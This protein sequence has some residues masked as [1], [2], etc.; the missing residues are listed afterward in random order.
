MS[1]PFSELKYNLY[2]ILN[3]SSNA[4]TQ[5]IKKAYAHMVKHF[6]PDKSNALD[7]DLFHHVT[8]CKNILLDPV[9]KSEY[10]IFLTQPK[11][12]IHSDLKTKF[13]SENKPKIGQT[14]F[15]A[16]MEELNKLHGYTNFTENKI[17]PMKYNPTISIE[18]KNFKNTNEFNNSFESSKEINPNEQLVIW[19]EEPLVLQSITMCSSLDNFEKLYVEDSVEDVNFT[20]L[21]RAFLLHPN[22]QENAIDMRNPAEIMDERMKNYKKN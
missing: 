13:K 18:K 14:N 21:N 10:D 22:R 11:D 8:A 3:V 6:H 7:M 1:N 15:N 12:L 4:T 17:N 20:S 5:E 9:V 19:K 16:K 2:E